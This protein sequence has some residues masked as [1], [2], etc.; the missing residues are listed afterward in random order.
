MQLQRAADVKLRGVDRGRGPRDQRRRRAAP[1]CGWRSTP[2]RPARSRPTSSARLLP[3]T[4]FGERTWSWSTR[5]TRPDGRIRAGAVIEPGPHRDRVELERVLDNA[6]PLLQ[7]SSPQDLAPRWARSPPRWRAAASSSANNLM[8][9]G[10]YLAEFNPQHAD[11]SSPDIAALADVA[12]TL[13]RRR[14]RPAADP[15]RPVGHQPR[16]SSRSRTPSPSSSPA[17]PG[18]RDTTDQRAHREREPDHPASARSAVPRSSCWREYSPIYPCFAEGLVGVGAADARHVRER[19]AA[20]HPRGRA[21]AAGLRAG[22]GAASSATTAGRTARAC[23]ARPAPSS[24]RTPATRHQ[25]RH[26]NGGGN[27]YAFVRHRPPRSTA[28]P[29][30]L[31]GGE[32]EQAARRLA[33]RPAMGLEP[34]EVPDIA[35]L[36]LGPVARGTEVNQ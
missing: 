27:R 9:V 2:T 5:R 31:V 20:H 17:Q 33:R 14:A 25:R 11:P 7:A 1:G 26:R 24:R 23:R 19:A 35:T 10:D 32:A 13:R 30:G 28:P 12:S 15:A 29:R 34:D 18:S 4:L 8:L 36:L 6:L 21:A 22:R 3:K 16:P